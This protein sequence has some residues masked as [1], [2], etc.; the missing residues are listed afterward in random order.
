M[1]D[2]DKLWHILEFVRGGSSIWLDALSID[3]DD[4]RDLAAQIAVMG[5]IYRD[6]RVVSVILPMEDRGAY[7]MLKE[8]AVIADEVVKRKGE[9]GMVIPGFSDAVLLGETS[10]S[11]EELADRYDGMISQWVESTSRWNYWSRAWTFQE[12]TMAAEIEI[13]WEGIPNHGGL[14]NIKNVI[15]SASTIIGHRRMIKAKNASPAST[16]LVA[17]AAVRAE[18]SKNLNLV[19]MHFP[20]QDFLVADEVGDP[21]ELRRRTILTPIHSISSGTSVETFKGDPKIP[22]LRRLLGLALTAISVS[23]RQARFEADL[24]HCWASMCNIEYDYNK[25]DPFNIALQKVVAAL[26]KAGISIFNFHANVVGGETDLKFMEYAAAMKHS[27]LE[28]GAYKFGAPIFVGRVDTLT[29]VRHCLKQTRGKVELPCTFEVMLQEVEKVEIRAPV[30]FDDGS[31][32]EAFKDLVSG[33]ADGRE[34]TD[35][36]DGLQSMLGEMICNSP[37]E[38]ERHQLVPVSITCID[39][40]ISWEIECWSICFSDIDASKLFVARESLN[41]TLVL[42]TPEVGDRAQIV[43]YLFMTHQRY[44]TYLIKTDEKGIADLV[45]RKS[46]PSL[47]NELL[48]MDFSAGPKPVDSALMAMM[49]IPGLGLM[50]TLDEASDVELT[51]GAKTYCAA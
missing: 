41:G 22:N 28:S 45:F 26:R 1:R 24:V 3:Q 27:N 42:A 43:A 20:F 46:E 51:L 38:L 50:D 23:K 32:V 37:E 40:G 47:I 36:A 30:S 44:G 31:I 8:L 49:N 48:N 9:F 39:S 17:Q 19:R 6:A 15:V 18:V 11:C 13:A 33:T 4:P 16:S 25:D 10:S 7:E 29:H 35:V 12:W 34:V 5:T 14:Q 2:V 21:A